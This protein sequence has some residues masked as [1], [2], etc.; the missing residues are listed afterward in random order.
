MVKILIESVKL[1]TP[2]LL[3]IK[4][5]NNKGYDVI[6]VEYEVTKKNLFRSDSN[7]IGDVVMSPN[8]GNSSIFYERSYCNFNFVRVWQE[9]S[10]LLRGG[11]DSSL[12]I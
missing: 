2:G 9:I 1:A 12:K 3:K 5:F 6:V 8:F 7:Y 10:L 11:F 4:I